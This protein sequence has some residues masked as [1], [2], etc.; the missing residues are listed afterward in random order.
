[1][2]IQGDNASVNHSNLVLAFMSC[3]VLQRVFT[4]V[5]VR[6]LLENHAHEIYD[7]FQAVSKNAV[8]RNTFYLLAEMID[9]L[10]VAH[11]RRGET[12]VR[13]PRA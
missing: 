2:T 7:A 1:M 5:R 3:Y 13:T 12:W 6:F 11:R 10:K 8:E 9:I 4:K